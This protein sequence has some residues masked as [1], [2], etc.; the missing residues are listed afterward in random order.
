LLRARKLSFKSA[1]EEYAISPFDPQR[2]LCGSL[3][4]LAA[5]P[6]GCPLENMHV[7]SPRREY[8]PR[9]RVD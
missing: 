3:R 6:S 8:S 7:I 2:S 5:P 4:K 1:Q 9:P